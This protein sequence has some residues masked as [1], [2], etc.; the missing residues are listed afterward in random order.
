MSNKPNFAK[1]RRNPLKEQY[2]KMVEKHSEKCDNR[3]NVYTCRSCGHQVKTVDE[4]FG[5]TPM[6]ITCD[7]CNDMMN[8]AMYKDTL[9][10]ERPTKGWYRPSFAEFQSLSEYGRNHVLKGGLL[11]R[12]IKFV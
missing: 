11:L 8:S 7:K 3:C 10:N 5:V 1:M 12:D 2:D 9:P 6:F 4:N